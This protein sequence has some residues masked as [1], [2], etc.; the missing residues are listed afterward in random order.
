VCPST[1]Q[2]IFLNVEVAQE[3]AR[4]VKCVFLANV[5]TTWSTDPILQEL[6]VVLELEALEHVCLEG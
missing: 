6:L 3:H 2:S 4:T 1:F 5:S